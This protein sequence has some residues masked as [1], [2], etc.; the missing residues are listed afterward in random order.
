MDGDDLAVFASF[1]YIT[2]DCGATGTAISRILARILLLISL[3]EFYD[4][5]LTPATRR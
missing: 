2:G 4:G 5:F 3:S 1:F